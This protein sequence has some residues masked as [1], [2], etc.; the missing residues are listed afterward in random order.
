MN[1]RTPK[2][3]FHNLQADVPGYKAEHPATLDIPKSM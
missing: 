3:T 2:S 1:P